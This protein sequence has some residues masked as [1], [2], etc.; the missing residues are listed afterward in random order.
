ML[1]LPSART[2][3][4]VEGRSSS[5]SRDGLKVLGTNLNRSESCLR[6][7]QDP[8]PGPPPQAGEGGDR[9]GRAYGQQPFPPNEELAGDT[10]A[11][12]AAEVG[13]AISM[14]KARAAMRVFMVGLHIWTIVLLCIG[15]CGRSAGACGREHGSAWHGDHRS[16][17]IQ[18]DSDLGL[19]PPPLAREGWGGGERKRTSLIACPLP[20]PPPRAGEGTLGHRRRA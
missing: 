3:L 2:V 20:I 4:T 18:N 7:L 16:R 10:G 12:L 1:S 13:N 5:V 6:P 11:A 19:L 8:L 14:A 17:T 9:V 15:A